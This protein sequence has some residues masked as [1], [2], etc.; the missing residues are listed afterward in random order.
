[1]TKKGTTAVEKSSRDVS[2]EDRLS[3]NAL[4]VF[5]RRYVRRGPDGEPMETVEGA[6]RRVAHHVAAV[7]EELRADPERA[8]ADFLDLMTHLR[9]LPNSP[10]FTGAGTPLAQL[11]ACF[12][13]PISDDMGRCGDGI[14]ET[15]RDMALIQQTGGG[16]GFSF[17]GLRPMG[18]VVRS[19][20]GEA[21]GPVGFMQV[22][23]TASEIIS[24][25]GARRGA[26]MAVLR[27][28]HPDIR[29]FIRCKSEEGAISNFNISVAVTDDFMRAVEKDS[30]VDLINPQDGE[31]WETVRA[32][33]IF[34]EIVEGA[35]RNGEP[36][37]LFLDAANRDNPTPHLGEYE[38]TNPCVT[39]DTLIAVADGR[40]YVP[41]R[42]L[43]EE[44][45]D[46]PVYCYGD[47]RVQIRMGR[48]PR[49]TRRQVEVWKVTLDDGSHI[50]A[51][52]DHK[53]R[54]RDF[55]EV[56]LR[57]LEPGVSLMPFYKYQFEIR[58]RQWSNDYWGTNLNNGTVTQEHRCVAEFHLG[59]W[60]RECEVIHQCDYNGLNNV[61]S[62]LEV[63]TQNEHLSLHQRGD[64]NVM[65][66]KWWDGL[67]EEEKQAYRDKMSDAVSGENNPMY[68]KHHTP[69]T[70]RKM[71]KAM[72]DFWASEKARKRQSGT[73]VQW[74]AEHGTEFLQGERVE[75]VEVPCAH[76]GET[77]RMTSNELAYRREENKSGEVFC[78]Q[79]CANYWRAEH[80][81]LIRYAREAVLEQGKTYYKDTG[82][83][84]TISEWDE[85][86]QS[87]DEVCCHETVRQRFGG[88]RKFRTALKE[89]LDLY[90]HEVVDI[91]P[92]GKADVYNITVDDF[93]TVAYLTNVDGV[94]HTLGKPLLSGVITSQC[95]E[96][97]LLPYENCC[98]GSI[99]LAQHV[100]EARGEGQE[101]RVD[102][103]KLAETVGRSVRFLDDV[104]DANGYVP[105]VPELEEAAKRS[106]RIGLGIMGLGDLMYH[107]RVR[108]GSEESFELA[109][110]VMEFI[111]YHAMQASIALAKERGP[112]P[113]I[114]GSVYDRDDLRWAPPEPLTPYERLERW[115]RPPLDWSAI[116]EGI[117]RHG[118]RNAA[119]TTIAPTGT[120]ATVAGCEAYGCEPVFALAYVRHMNDNGKDVELRYAG[121]L[122][123]QALE[124][125]GLDEET[126]ERIIEQV[127]RT[128]SCQEVEEVPERIRQVFVVAQDIPAEEH[129]R[130]QAALQAFVDASISKCVAGDTLLFTER[131]ILPIGDLRQNDPPDTF[132]TLN[133]PL[134]VADWGGPMAAQEFYFGGE[135]ETICLTTGLGLRLEAT[136]NH[137]VRVLEAGAAS[138]PFSGEGD[139]IVWRRMDELRDG[140]Y[141]VVPYD[142]PEALGRRY[143]FSQVYGMTYQAAERTVA[144]TFSLPYKMTRDLA[145]LLGY[146]TADGYIGENWVQLSQS[147]DQVVEDAKKI[148]R[149][150]FD[151]EAKHTLDERREHLNVLQVNGRDLVRFFRDYLGME[152]LAS[153]KHIPRCVTA[154]GPWMARDYVRGL[155]L[156]GYVSSQGRVVPLTTTSERLARETQALLLALG[157]PTR[158]SMK[159]IDYEYK[160]GREGSISYEITVL[161][162]FRERFLEAIGFAEKRKN[163]KAWDNL[164]PPRQ[165][166]G[167]QVPGV[168]DLCIALIKAKLPHVR[169]RRVEDY[170]RS[171]LSDLR[172]PDKQTLA[173]DRIRYMLDLC[174]DQAD[175]DEYRRLTR[176]TKRKVVYTPVTS[177]SKGK[178][179]VYDL[180]VPE[181]NSF[182]SNGLLSHNTINCPAD[183]TP[184]DVARA[185]Q[186]A[187]KLG[188]K[189]LTVYVTGS[190][191]KVVL[192]TE[193]TRRASKRRAAMMVSTNV[194]PRPHSLEG[195]T[196]RLDTPL[197][198]AYIT[199]NVNGEGEPFEVFLN[200]GKAGSDTAAVAEA[201][202]RLISLALRIP[203]PLSSTRRLKQV[204]KQLKG[205][206][207]GRSLG[208]GRDRVRSLPDGVAQVL[209]EHLGLA[210]SPGKAGLSEQLPL[211]PEG[212]LCPECGQ[213]TLVYEEGCQH[214]YACGYSEC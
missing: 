25:G 88:F 189:G 12:L 56:A 108:Y 35:H 171:T 118:I 123:R 74:F 84:P 135:Q 98:L 92:A 37:M 78:S 94:T 161:P 158:L 66:P 30:T 209:A 11:A 19:S 111:R 140:D 120:R 129:V 168:I 154:S 85:W 192:E 17:S 20:G 180:H 31:V 159:E 163:R 182:I 149:R 172:Q 60:L 28:D 26:N 15:L 106:R 147:D 3:E 69:E 55:T 51:T 45:K 145:R 148:F 210:E 101:A 131:G 211:F 13:L 24:Q 40:D 97:P 125:A 6:F 7:E 139:N 153:E 8:E 214:C 212:D 185:F 176:V 100:R 155:T 128:G 36:G 48:N 68:G 90:N 1:M 46:V 77:L 91:R 165:R 38:A 39:G 126:R 93:H 181:T 80:T 34:D 116:V 141:L 96:Q 89:A 18:A 201:I 102:W 124:Q 197:G 138:L 200:V 207:G 9:F 191:E 144:N 196:Y 164:P 152:G 206:G 107:L 81:K 44:G 169:S 10:T 190:R 104:I 178:A 208:F 146:L 179:P 76:C 177:L 50:I 199:V 62:N 86:R 53:F 64:R 198:T 187:W 41:I 195:K 113:A 213:A 57:D 119:Q 183:A 134:R 87:R 99:N 63:M 22:Y 95:G 67:S 70:R 157:I 160:D 150:R 58:K 137:R 32:R 156:D 121:P 184:D 175:T 49:L 29:E 105:A 71:G 14:F 112:F 167:N 43:A 79:T 151:A 2:V 173:I 5:K 33:E 75:R 174:V 42:Q 65:R 117:R 21:T 204:V 59:R 52:P 194:R 122:F 72:S 133:D 114:E 202:G 142:Y 16:T 110:Q 205:I 103:E 127:A 23:D 109:A 166:R 73:R 54:L 203:S 162:E 136:P 4:N 47:G 130:M 186:L 143:E 27:A 115:G 132:R 61:W 170:L 188:C 193:E 82:K 83:L